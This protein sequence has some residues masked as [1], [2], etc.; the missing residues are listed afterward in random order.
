M[1]W[2][3]SGHVSAKVDTKKSKKICAMKFCLPSLGGDEEA[4]QG[5][6][7]TQ[8]VISRPTFW[9]ALARRRESISRDSP[10]GRGCEQPH[11]VRAMEL[12]C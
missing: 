1:L 3:G 12:M 10:Q 4:R 2:R 9:T 5:C 6:G 11:A 8:E 7:T